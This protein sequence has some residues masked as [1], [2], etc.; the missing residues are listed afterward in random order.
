MKIN[1]NTRQ[2]QMNRTLVRTDL[3]EQLVVGF[4]QLPPKAHKSL[5]N[6]AGLQIAY[7]GNV[8]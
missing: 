3:L 5:A 8:Q 7:M 4:P 6:F 2:I 1:D